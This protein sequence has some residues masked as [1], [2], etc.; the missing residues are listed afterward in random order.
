MHV[1]RDPCMF[2]R[3]YAVSMPRGHFI[4][5]PDGFRGQTA[6][7]RVVWPKEMP[8]Q[9]RSRSVP[10]KEDA[11]Y[12]LDNSAVFM[13]AIAGASGPFVFR[14][15]CELDETVHLREL[16]E[17]L[18]ALAPRFPFLF[19]VLRSGVFWH[20]LDPDDRPPSVEAEARAPARPIRRGRSL[21]RV[22]AFGRRI[23]CEFHHAVTDGTGA[24]AL[25]RALL[26]EYF[27][28]RGLAEVPAELLA[29]IPRPGD[30]VDAGEEEDAY[31]R[32]FKPTA[33]VPDRSPKAFRLGGTRR[34]SGYRETVATVPLAEALAAAKARNASLT[35][36]LAAV[37][38]ATLQD[39]HDAL[40]PRRRRRARKV[41]SLQIPVNLRKIYPSRTLRNFFLFAAPSMDLR[42]GRWEFDE[43]LR[44]VHHQL[45][46]GM[47]EKELL[48]QLKRNVGG[49]RNPFG[50][51][52][53]LP[54]KTLVLRIINA[55][56]G[57]S[58]YSG[59]LSN[60]GPIDLPSPIAAHVVGFSLLPSRSRSTGAN[61]CVLSWKDRLHI[62]VGSVLR[63]REFE[64]RFLSRLVDLGL[65]VEAASSEGWPRAEAARKGK[66]K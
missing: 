45:R 23:A 65:P 52:V 6:G 13:A 50:R 64:R 4:A 41:I 35:E 9:R 3:I 38:M 61:V 66:P 48:R 39:L 22:T 63:D 62:T 42:L 26:V 53:F 29:G 40:P 11:F 56:I 18:S 43:I 25:M 21:V 1:K 33:T 15:S 30:P 47:E 14:L 31:A 12:P 37:H 2:L 28:R 16:Q 36:F 24:V 51:P 27:L 57:V 17:A 20:Y 19:A 49:E 55:T 44:R 58:A 7:C 59:S 54:I 32:V 46:L 10:A 5:A 34:V 60:I 8:T